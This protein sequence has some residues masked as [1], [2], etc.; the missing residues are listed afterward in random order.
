MKL[1][2]NWNSCINFKK[3]IYNNL[4]LVIDEQYRFGVKQRVEITEKGN[5]VNVLVMTER[6]YL[7]LSHWLLM[8]IWIF[9]FCEKPIG[10]KLINTYVLSQTKIAEVLSSIERAIKAGAL[11]Y[12]PIEDPENSDSIALTKDIFLKNNFK[13]LM[14]H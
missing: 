8:V 13:T 2:L 7:D 6:L 9:L 5:N 11:V 1:K 12:C 10:R 4:S 14:F 3:V